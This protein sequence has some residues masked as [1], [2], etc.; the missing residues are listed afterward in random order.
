M[1]YKDLTSVAPYGDDFNPDLNFLRILFTPGRAVQARELTQLQT[2]LQN[3]VSLFANHFFKN[4]STILGAKISTNASKP[5][6]IAHDFTLADR[7]L[8]TLSG[9][10]ITSTYSISNFVGRT[11]VN[12]DPL[13]P[14]ADPPT[15]SITIT[16]AFEGPGLNEITLYYTFSGSVSVADDLFYDAAGSSG[17]AFK[18]KTGHFLGLAAYCEPG[19]IY[20]NGYFVNVLGQEIV[21]DP[22]YPTGAN[23]YAI[24]FR[25]DEDIVTESDQFHGGLLLDNAAGFYNYVAPGAHRYRV[26]PVLDY[27]DKADEGT[28]TAEF[29]EAFSTYVEV[30]ENRLIRDQRDTEYSKILDLLARRT[31]DESGNYTVKAFDLVMKDDTVDDD[32]LIAELSPGKAYVLGY[33]IN[34]IVSEQVS[35][36]KARE[37]TLVNNNFALASDHF[38]LVVD[39]D[40]ATANKGAPKIHGD[41]SLVRGT[42]VEA[43]NVPRGTVAS[44]STKIGTAK[45][46]SLVKVGEEVRLYLT[47]CSGGLTQNAGTAKTVRVSTDY[48]ASGKMVE[49]STL[50]ISTTRSPAGSTA[51]GGSNALSLI[52]PLAGA[53]VT[54]SVADASFDFSVV[55]EGT[56]S[57]GTSTGVGGA[58]VYTVTFTADINDQTFFS[59]SETGGSLF[60]MQEN[61]GGT[62]TTFATADINAV[63]TT[64]G[65]PATCTVEILSTST[66]ASRPV[67]AYLRTRQ[68]VAPARQ[69][70]LTNYTETVVC[71]NP[72]SVGKI[73]LTKEDCYE[74]VSIKQTNNVKSGLSVPYELT[75]ADMAKL[76]FDN[77]QR[78]HSYDPGQVSGL[79]KLTSYNSTSASTSFEV[80]YKYFE[81]TGDPF[82]GYFSVGSYPFT[83]DELELIPDF[84][85]GA[86]QTFELVNCLDFRV[87]ASESIGRTLVLPSNRVTADTEFYYGRIDKLCVDSTGKF[88]LNKG[89]ASFKPEVPSEIDNAMTLFI[90]NLNPYTYDRKDVKLKKIENKRY[91][92]RDI[93]KL[94]KRIENLEIYTVMSQLEQ[95]VN[96]LSIVDA[97]TGFDKFKNGLFADPF[98]N[99]SFAD[100]ENPEYRVAVDP[101]NGGI[102]CPFAR[103]SFELAPLSGSN[104]VTVWDSIATLTPIGVEV[105][106]K[107]EYASNAINVNPYLFFVWNGTVNLSPSV[108]TWFETAYAPEI[109][110]EEGS[111]DAP[112]TD[113]GTVW[114]D[115]QLNWVGTSY[116][117]LSNPEIRPDGTIS[118]VTRN[119]TYTNT[120]ASQTRTGTQVSWVPTT[121]TSVQDRLI[122]TSQIPYMRPTKVTVK[123]K[124]LRQGM[125]IK[126]YLDG[127]LMTLIPSSATFSETSPIAP[128]Y[129]PKSD[130]LG[131]F[132]GYFTV[133]AGTIT[134]GTKSFYLVD[135]DNTSSAT[136]T[137]TSS[138]IL[139]TRQ[140]T[141]TTVRGVDEVRTIV[142]DTRELDTPITSETR[143]SGTI[144]FDPI[145]QSF[146]VD[147]AG[148]CF[149]KSIEVF[150]KQKPTTVDADYQPVT[151]YIVEMENGSPTQRIVPFSIATLNPSQ[152]TAND[153]TPGLGGTEFIFSDPVYLEEGSE[154]AF[155]LF[156][157]S[158]K[159]LT[160]ISTLGEVDIFN[161]TPGGAAGQPRN[162]AISS[163]ATRQV[164]KAAKFVSSSGQVTIASDIGPDSFLPRIDPAIAFRGSNTPGRGIAEQ[165][166]LGSLFKSQNA[167][168]WTPDQMSDITFRIKKYVFPINTSQILTLR[169]TKIDSVGASIYPS[170]T[171]NFKISTSM[172]NV[173]DLALP[174]TSLSYQQAFHAGTTASG[175]TPVLNRE[176]VEQPT[177]YLLDNVANT[178]IRNN[179]TVVATFRSVN[180]NLSPVIDLEQTRLVGAYYLLDQYDLSKSPVQTLVTAA[181]GYPVA[182]TGYDAGTYV[183][184][185]IS[186]LNESDDL[187]V[188][189][190]AKIPTGAGIRVMYRTTEAERSYIEPMAGTVVGEGL[191]SQTCRLLYRYGTAGAD[192]YKVGDPDNSSPTTAVPNF[193]ST[194]QR[195]V[196]SGYDPDGVGSV[197]FRSSTN[198]A[199]IIAPTGNIDKVM[200]VSESVAEDLEILAAVDVLKTKIPAWSSGV[201]YGNGTN[202]YYVLHGGRLWR[203]N[204]V[205]YPSGLAAGSATTFEPTVGGQAWIDTPYIDVDSDPLIEGSNDGWRPM[206]L[207]ETINDGLD[208]ANQF[209]EYTYIPSDDPEDFTNF[210]IKIEMYSAQKNRVPECRNLRA[211]AVI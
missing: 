190:D 80:V 172:L 168:T 15:K 91:T 108:D 63:T 50:A 144:W 81:H 197:F 90:V 134:T 206:E 163:S 138:G 40:Q 130:S 132:E 185:N 103:N 198:S 5:G 145:A 55:K 149:L 11:Y 84:S 2:I 94:E 33:E 133:P 21:V 205:L 105:M 117:T 51:L 54:K 189:V 41:L 83:A 182:S 147:S 109:Q 60:C 57:A 210:A 146:L 77:G 114:N 45:V 47:E 209:I 42:E 122:N 128:P 99:H 156:T 85:S 124:G 207:D 175:L 71:A 36:D 88:F 27:F 46:H 62:W 92:M 43:H 119:T 59:S 150:F 155:V 126:G 34:K 116:T 37:S 107:N 93:G 183:S 76:S 142:S 61:N 26:T 53:T 186:L 203:V 166:Y 112:D 194:N 48:T 164:Y 159:Y 44:S 104:T 153:V 79:E 1:S 141:I 66:G 96:N 31:Y 38:Y 19:I 98:R 127:V 10:S 165:P 148:G 72:S 161:Y 188:L 97:S 177:E 8:G 106:A 192:Q 9:T 32:K 69:K 14:S 16:H 13:N 17:V 135:E 171:S 196:I 154:Y 202:P 157:N 113:Y 35:V 64:I 65:P 180:G 25:F 102:R 125:P 160:W 176:N 167:T 49:C 101:L 100:K 39:L 6:L 195:I 200:I 181:N 143:T 118:S 136:T 24:G 158:R 184:K 120:A 86:G 82:A 87:K 137:Y 152:V 123:A 73:I 162:I 111:W 131:N 89:V 95:S 74:I 22:G 187:R 173:G 204:S 193:A 30:K 139:N 179:Y 68:T 115:W 56:L 70:V 7:D 67:R 23:H 191:I 29:S 75:A 28:L 170:S 178:A 169:D 140:R 174:G 211:I 201:D 151:L 58:T 12:E 121:S 18:V 4:N 110:N 20:R 78:R 129:K 3:Q 199:R 208:T 52:Y